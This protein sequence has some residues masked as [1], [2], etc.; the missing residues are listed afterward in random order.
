MF[1]ASIP[2]KEKERIWNDLHS[3]SQSWFETYNNNGKG[4][5]MFSLVL[6]GIVKHMTEF[7]YENWLS[8]DF[9]Y[10]IQLQM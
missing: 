6:D 8:H 2:E 5:Q 1:Y 4:Y 3:S 7:H 9:E 10:T